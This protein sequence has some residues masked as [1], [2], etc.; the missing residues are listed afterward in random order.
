GDYIW[1]HR[2]DSDCEA[3]ILL[4][5]RTPHINYLIIV[6]QVVESAVRNKGDACPR[7]LCVLRWR[8]AIREHQSCGN[9]QNTI[10]QHT[11]PLLDSEVDKLQF[12]IK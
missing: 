7:G 10:I 12:E 5:R 4:H 2:W 9:W 8:K 6:T 3:V 11:F 1:R